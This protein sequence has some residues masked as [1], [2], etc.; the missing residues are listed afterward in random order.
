MVLHCAQLLV[1]IPVGYQI[2]QRNSKVLQL[3]TVVLSLHVVSRMLQSLSLLCRPVRANA[4]QR[5]IDMPKMA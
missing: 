2:K 3:V 4:F 1:S 5:A